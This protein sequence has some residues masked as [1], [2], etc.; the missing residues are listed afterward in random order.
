MDIPPLRPEQLGWQIPDQILDFR[1]TAELAPLEQIIGQDSALAGLRRGVEMQSPGFNVFVVGI[2][3]TGRLNT[4]RR[5]VRKLDPPRR[6][7]RDLVYVANFRDPARPRL[8]QFPP[9]RGIAFRRELLRVAAALLEEVP[10]VMRSEEF[11]ERRDKQT[12]A[13]AVAHQGALQRLQ[14]HARE[15]G[16]LVAE[17][18]EGEDVEPVVLWV[19][20]GSMEADPDNPT[21]H[22]RA[23]LQVAAE[24]GDIELPRPVED[25]LADF[26]MLEREL[27]EV[28]A[29]SRQVVIETLRAVSE[30]EQEAVR[31]ATER[32]FADL[33]R[34]WPSARAWLEELHEEVVENPEWFDEESDHEALLAAFTANLVHSGSRSRKAP[35]VVVPNPTWQHLFGG[36]EGEPGAGDHRAIRGGLLLDA[37]GGFLII[38]A[39]DL[40][41]E[42]NT[43]K[44]LKR[45]LMFGEM[46]ISNPEMPV[47]LGPSVM[48]PDAL[49]LD[50]KV[51]LLGDPDTYAALYYGDQ[52]FASIFKIKAEFEADA[53]CTPDLLRAYA[54]FMARVVRREKLGHLTRDAVASVLEWAVREAG[55]GGRITTHFGGV[56]D[57]L[58]EASHESGGELIES[59]HVHAALQ[60]RRQR[61]DLGE[62]RVLEMMES[63]VIRVDVDGERVGQSNALV[64]YHVG[65]HDFGRP[66]RI[67]ATV[68]VGRGGVVSIERMARLSGRSHDKGIQILVGLLLDRFGQEGRLSFTASLCFEQSYGRIDGD[69]AS[70]PE[71]IALFSALSGVPLRQYVAMTGSINQ[72]G[73]IQAVGGVNEKIEGF[74]SSCRI[75][76]LT[77]R[78]GV[79]IPHHNVP[80]LCL[81][82]EVRRACAEG[83]FHVWGVRT[84]EESIRLMMGVD[85]GERT[86]DG[87]WTEGS[88]FGRTAATLDRFRRLGGRR[89]ERSI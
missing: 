65:G 81:S 49:Q 78:Q 55:R 47:M 34:R 17:L 35:V 5:I 30:N 32:I 33:A 39:T 85:P 88:V 38:N 2:Q 72:F 26:A 23:E 16:F 43:W 61:D 54:G 22:T 9:G 89:R 73:E 50:V 11:R 28:L 21:V 1:T 60:A 48:R 19:E 8:L 86:P 37:D 7:A 71:A 87:G 46:D 83:R 15:R 14:A 66:M 20:P 75:L 6:S 45:S 53:P 79:V 62:R 36:V 80:D 29:V 84:L 76:G 77:G 56:A 74:Y 41:Q 40:L 57:L 51:I 52:D 69:S 27:S 13:S 70:A 67:T 63:G 3:T 31:R 58:R 42:P 59:H 4:V 25:I 12:H 64:V 24:S 68:G 10:E 44:V 18:G 82:P